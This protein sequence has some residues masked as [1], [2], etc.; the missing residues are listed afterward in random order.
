MNTA[1]PA[2][3][4]AA[5]SLHHLGLRLLLGIAAL[6][7]VYSAFSVISDLF[8]GHQGSGIG[9][10]IAGRILAV[11]PVLA[12]AALLFALIC[13]VRD[14]I[15]MLGALVLVTWLNEM[16]SVVRHGLEF[17]SSCPRFKPPRKSSPSR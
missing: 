4:D 14:A 7:E 2:S 5:P 10:A 9:D 13:R 3:A 16:P 11:H 12:P 17:S 15:L 6:L 8:T 1:L